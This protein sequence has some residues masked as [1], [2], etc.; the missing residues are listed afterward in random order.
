MAHGCFSA[1]SPQLLCTL[2]LFLVIVVLILILG[3]TNLMQLSFLGS[4]A[5]FKTCAVL[6]QLERSGMLD[7]LFFL[8]NL[9]T[10]PKLI[11]D[12]FSKARDLLPVTALHVEMVEGMQ[13]LTWAFFL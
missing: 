12:Q 13:I 5:Q 11:K 10:R 2:H 7:Y 6:W 8:N 1:R 9:K 3:Q 4:R